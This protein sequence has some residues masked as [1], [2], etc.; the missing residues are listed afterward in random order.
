MFFQKQP[1][2]VFCKKGV[3]ISFGKLTGEHLCQS[4]FFNKVAGFACLRPPEG[5]VALLKK[6]IWHWCFLVIFAK[7]LITPF[8]RTSLG[9]LFEIGLRKYFQIEVPRALQSHLIHHIGMATFR[10]SCLEVFCKKAVL[11]HFAKFTGKHL[12]QSLFFNKAAGLSGGCFCTFRCVTQNDRF[13]KFR[14]LLFESTFRS[15]I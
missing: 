13:G 4:L 1:P 9:G 2:E 11:S 6:R 12:C 7:F 5:P 10:S 14:E 15:Q 3:L 8:Y